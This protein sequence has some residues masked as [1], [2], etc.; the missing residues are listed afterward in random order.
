MKYYL[1]TTLAL[2]CVFGSLGYSF[3]NSLGAK[4]ATMSTENIELTCRNFW[5]YKP[6]EFHLDNSDWCGHMK[7]R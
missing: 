3:V 4:E 2:A 7:G 1:V 5:Q 6:G